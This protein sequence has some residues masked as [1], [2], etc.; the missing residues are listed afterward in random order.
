MQVLRA[1]KFTLDPT[2]SQQSRLAR[3]AGAARWA[4]N[5]ALSVKM[6]AHKRWQ[7]EV[8]KLA[9]SGVPEGEARK[10]TKITIPTKAIIQKELNAHKG[11]SR[12]NID[13]IC[14]WW[15]EVSTYCFQS[16]FIDADQAWKNWLDSFFKVRPGRHIGYPQFKKKNLTRESFRLYHDVKRPTIRLTTYR[17]LRVP[18]IGD[19]RLHDSGKRLARLINRGDAV[20]Q[21][22]AISRTGRRWHASVL[23]KINTKLPKKLTSL[24]RSSGRVGV[25][26]DIAYF[27]TLSA[28]LAI[29]NN[30]TAA[31]R[32]TIAIPRHLR[33]A[34]RRLEKS[35]RALARSQKGS[36]RHEKALGRTDRLNYQL[37]I[38]REAATHQLTKRL[39]VTFAEIAIESLSAKLLS[40][41]NGSKLTRRG[42]RARRTQMAFVSPGELR[43]QLTYKTHWYG[44]KLATVDRSWPISR[45]CSG[46]GWRDPSLKLPDRE[47]RC[48]NQSCKLIIDRRLNEARSIAAH[49]KFTLERIPANPQVA[50]D[51]RE[52]E[53][54]RGACV[55]PGARRGI[56]QLA[57][58]R[59]DTVHMGTVPPQ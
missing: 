8:A 55:S 6:A 5:H 11:D 15:H 2:Q 56:R 25:D 27:A 12:K 16:A 44:S 52:T 47:F 33:A 35:Q 9:A 48:G 38:R 10:K 30:S 42:R 7:L 46:C 45:T 34:A 51:R 20:V 14:P 53:N 3:H 23:C 59:E 4:F 13:G 28:P 50:C 1:F 17:R 22:V 57:L 24:Q 32:G 37:A 40:H 26:L 49:A 31:L 43:R 54:A 18:A 58:K 21:S 41:R 36:A 39:A 29:N 19:I